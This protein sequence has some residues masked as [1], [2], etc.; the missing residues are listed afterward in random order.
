MSDP[1]LETFAGATY[2]PLLAATPSGELDTEILRMAPAKARPLCF[3]I[4]QGFHLLSHE[5][6][7]RLGE[8]LLDDPE[9]ARWA[10]GL[11]VMLNH[12]VRHHVDVYGTALG[13]HYLADLGR[14]YRLLAGGRRLGTSRKTICRVDDQAAPACNVQPVLPRTSC[15]DGQRSGDPL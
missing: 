3:V 13:L 2:N 7:G 14:E 8:L 6:W 10:L 1:F 15:F 4:A 11:A 9:A 5:P 12:E